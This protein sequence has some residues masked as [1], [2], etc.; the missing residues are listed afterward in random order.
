[1]FRAD[2]RRTLEGSGHQPSSDG[3]RNNGGLFWRCRF[4]LFAFRETV[5]VVLCLDERLVG[6]HALVDLLFLIGIHT[7][8][9]WATAA[10]HRSFFDGIQSIAE[11]RSAGKLVC[12]N[13]QED[14]DDGH[15]NPKQNR[16]GGGNV[17]T[18]R[19]L[20][21][22]KLTTN[23]HSALDAS[24]RA[25]GI[26]FTALGANGHGVLYAAPQ[27]SMGHI[28]LIPQFVPFV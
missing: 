22:S 27:T 1:M 23:G 17:G 16:E 8:R 15:G 7:L 5:I 3:T 13:Y 20:S 26:V 18:L 21:R 19:I 11:I 10:L 14:D 12:R 2:F 24:A 25:V 6:I 28:Q 9:D 4:S